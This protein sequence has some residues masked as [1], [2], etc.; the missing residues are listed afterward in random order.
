[1]EGCAAIL[2]NLEL[3]HRLLRD[4]GLV[5][6]FAGAMRDLSGVIA[7]IYRTMVEANVRVLQTGDAYNAVHCL[8]PG[9][10]ADKAADALRLEFHLT[11]PIHE[12]EVAA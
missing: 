11:R 9:G 10:D 6:T 2:A 3:P 7:R 12:L 4:L 8:V 1:M 5:S